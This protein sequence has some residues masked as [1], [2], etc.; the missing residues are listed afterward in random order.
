MTTTF[1]PRSRALTLAT[2]GVVV[3]M[4]LTACGNDEAEETVRSTVSSTTSTTS[5]TTSEED[6]DGE[7]SEDEGQ[8]QEFA[9]EGG[10]YHAPS[11]GAGGAGQGEDPFGGQSVEIRKLDPIE[12]GPASDADAQAIKGLV[13]GIYD[14]TS[15]HGFML[16]IPTRSCQRV[17]DEH[18]GRA[19][20]DRQVEGIP[21]MPM[22]ELAGWGEAGVS[23]VEDIRVNGNQ[24]SASV[25]VVGADGTVDTS[26][27]RF[28]REGGN[29]TFCN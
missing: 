15:F 3:S 25:T 19:A 9:S 8:P 26:V 12:G 22:S 6:E 29:W 7:P 5:T 17:I 1:L 18:G 21:D 16:Y 4:T 13:N 10:N 14:E 2:V 23:T 24:A 28:Q 20:I 11:P 27:M